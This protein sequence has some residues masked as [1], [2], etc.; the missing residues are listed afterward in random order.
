MN[1]WILQTVLNASRCAAL[2]RIDRS[3]LGGDP[4]CICGKISR[5]SPPL[6]YKGGVIPRGYSGHRSENFAD[7]ARRNRREKVLFFEGAAPLLCLRV[8]SFAFC[9]ERCFGRLR[10][11]SYSRERTH[12]S[13]LKVSLRNA[14][15]C[16]YA[17]MHDI[18]FFDDLRAKTDWINR[19]KPK[20]SVF[21]ISLDF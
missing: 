2:V 19:P 15:E 11:C 17:C 18:D 12:S 14:P 7:F 8:C 5:A 21:G 9:V 6:Y 10:S 4:A 1:F 16:M 3:M 13:F 20:G